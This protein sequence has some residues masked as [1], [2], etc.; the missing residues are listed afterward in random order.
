MLKFSFLSTVPIRL[1]L[2]L[3]ALLQVTVLPAQSPAKPKLD[4]N[5]T[6]S[7]CDYRPGLYILELNIFNRYFIG[8]S[9]GSSDLLYTVSKGAS[10]GGM[11]HLTFLMG[12]NDSE[13]IQ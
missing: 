11:K 1:F 5:I 13:D 10:G 9:L 7:G 2:S 3:S 6:V 12:E 4:L 8:A